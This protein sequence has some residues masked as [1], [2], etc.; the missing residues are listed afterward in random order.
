M[1]NQAAR[2]LLRAGG[3]KPSGRSKP[4]SEYLQR[5]CGSLQ[6]INLAVDLCNL[7]SLASGLPISVVDLTKA[8]APFSIS[9]VSEGSYLFNASGQSIDLK[10]LLCLWD[11]QGPCANAVK[12]SQRTKTS[13][14]TQ[15]TLT[16]I[17]GSTA[18][19]GYSS[20]VFQWYSTLLQ[21]AGAQVQRI[22]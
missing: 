17:W 11:S 3:F 18:L 12:D 1:I 19:P 22:S 10:T 20:Q 4:A 14:Q 15:S 6:S 8:Q 5:E 2:A 7:V 9:V 16:V 21:Q 13:S